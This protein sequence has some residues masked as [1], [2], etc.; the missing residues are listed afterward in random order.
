MLIVGCYNSIT[1]IKIFELNSP[2]FFLSDPH[3]ETAIDMKYLEL[4]KS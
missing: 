1:V 2:A 3:G 4:N